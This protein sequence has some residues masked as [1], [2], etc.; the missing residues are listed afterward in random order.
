MRL[1]NRLILIGIILITIP[2]I[3]WGVLGENSY[4]RIF[5]SLDSEIVHLKLILDSSDPIGIHSDSMVMGVMNGLP[6]YVFRG[7]FSF[8]LLLFSLFPFIYAYILNHLIVHLIGFIGMFLLLNRY[9]LKNNYLSFVI[10]LIFGFLSYHHIQNGI[11]ISGQPLLLWVFMNIIYKHKNPWNWVVIIL[12]PFFSFIPITLPFIIPMLVVY[13]AYEY[14]VNKRF[15]WN[16]VWGMV[17]L[18]SINI[19]IE[20]NLFQGLFLNPDYISHRSEWY[21]M[22][23]E[24][25]EMMRFIADQMIDAFTEGGAHSGIMSSFPALFLVIVASVFFKI[26]ASTKIKMLL[27]LLLFSYLWVILN[28]LIRYYIGPYVEI[29]RTFNIMRFNLFI[30]LFLLLIIASYLN[31]FNWRK[32]SHA[33]IG[34]GILFYIFMSTLWFNDEVN[35]NLRHV[36]GKEVIEPTYEKF[37]DEDLF[38]EVKS[39]L[40]EKEIKENNFL[41]LGLYPGILQYNQIST[42]GGYQNNYP[43]EYKYEFRKIIVEEMKKNKDIHRNFDDWGSRCYLFSSELGITYY[44]SKEILFP[45]QNLNINTDQIKK[46]NGKYILSAVQIMNYQQLNLHFHKVFTRSD[47]PYELHL[48]EVK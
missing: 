16:Y 22:P 12:F 5:D 3:F 29:F 24:S 37:Y 8:T 15:E 32:L 35:L 47:S 1:Q 40:G 38:T 36:V 28:E 27:G 13:G 19:I 43:L 23:Y 2:H 7:G 17:L 18:V 39:Y 14:F 34:I 20:F 33:S 31:E 42:L 11:S 41:A 4:I 25:G 21:L 6:R 9:F 48:Y 46:M 44:R 10:A 26:K 45:I 30:P